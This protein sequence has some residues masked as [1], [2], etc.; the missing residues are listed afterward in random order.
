MADQKSGI[1]TIND[2]LGIVNSKKLSSPAI[3]VIGEVV[4]E[5]SELQ[6]IHDQVLMDLAS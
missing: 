1:G 3:I 5:S 4:K 6:V 2:I